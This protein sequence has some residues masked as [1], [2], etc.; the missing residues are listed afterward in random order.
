MAYLTK[1][2]LIKTKLFGGSS[3]VVWWLGVSTS[4]VAA[5]IQSL[6]GTQIPLPHQAATHQ[7]QKK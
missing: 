4:T 3:L 5:Q 2:S 7:G 1:S 6:V